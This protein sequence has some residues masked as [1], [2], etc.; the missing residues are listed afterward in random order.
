MDEQST[1]GTEEV[2]QASRPGAGE[3]LPL[4]NFD[5]LSESFRGAVAELSR[6]RSIPAITSGAQLVDHINN[7]EQRLNLARR[8]IADLQRSVNTLE[9][10][11]AAR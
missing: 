1:S 6:S 7:Q 5:E 2:G 11:L 3:A 4:P 10:R 8:D 9:L